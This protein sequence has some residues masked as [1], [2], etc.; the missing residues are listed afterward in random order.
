MRMGKGRYSTVRTKGRWL[1]LL[2]HTKILAGCMSAGA[3]SGCLSREEKLRARA[4]V[5]LGGTVHVLGARACGPCT[6]RGQAWTGTTDMVAKLL[7]SPLYDAQG[8]AW[9]SD[10][11]GHARSPPG[12]SAR[13]SAPATGENK[14][15]L[16]PLLILKSNK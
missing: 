15:V 16:C 12:I 13:S 8:G 2:T 5:E 3:D 10:P 11:L 9:L 14:S 6:I 4:S 7:K 1:V